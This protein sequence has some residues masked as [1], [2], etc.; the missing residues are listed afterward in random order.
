MAFGTSTKELQ[1]VPEIDIPILFPD[2]VLEPLNRT[3]IDHEGYPAA[4]GTNDVIIM[5]LR[6]DEFKVA[7]GPVQKNFLRNVQIL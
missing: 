2:S 7:A 1:R 4:L 6:I 5:L 3:R